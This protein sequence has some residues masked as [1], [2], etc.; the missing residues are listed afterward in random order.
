MCTGLPAVKFG[1]YDPS[2][3]TDPKVVHG[4]NCTLT[5]DPGFDVKGPSVKSCGGKKSGI[6]SSRSKQPKCIGKLF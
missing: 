2:D 1:L 3:C 6:W 5:C 4:T